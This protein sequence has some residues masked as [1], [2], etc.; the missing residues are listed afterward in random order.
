MFGHHHPNPRMGRGFIEPII[1][2]ALSE[3]PM[4]GYEIMTHLEQQSHGFWRPSAGSVYPTLQLLEDKGHIASQ[5]E[6]GKKIYVITDEGKAFLANADQSVP[7]F[8]KEKLRQHGGSPFDRNQLRDIMG[9]MRNI[10]KQNNADKN[11]RLRELL[12][13]FKTDLE[14]LAAE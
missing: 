11:A 10:V 8:W 5:L 2:Q 7:E 6:D 4:H 9:N 1:L 14:Q 12:V 13:Q 3:K